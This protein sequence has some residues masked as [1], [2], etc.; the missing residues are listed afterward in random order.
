MAAPVARC[1]S[2]PAEAL[3]GAWSWLG[4]EKSAV[5]LESF[6]RCPLLDPPYVTRMQR[7]RLRAS[8]GRLP[9]FE[10]STCRLSRFNAHGML[11]LLAGRTLL[12][13]GDSVTEQHFHAVA[14]SLLIG[15]GNGV[16]APW[17][18]QNATRLELWKTRSCLPFV[19]DVLLCYVRAST[20]SIAG[21]VTRKLRD[22]SVV[23][24]YPCV[25]CWSTASSL[26]AG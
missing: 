24:R 5:L 22:P 25:P 17:W 14:C 4:A 7:A 9:V 12:F 18:P 1:F 15:G 10:P 3:R 16:L 2:S 26:N 8:E 23:F 21:F 19:H 6:Y 13:L 11:K 20:H